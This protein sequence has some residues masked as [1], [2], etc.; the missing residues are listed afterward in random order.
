MKQAILVIALLVSSGPIFGDDNST[1][2]HHYS[3]AVVYIQQAAQIRRSDFTDPTFFDRFAMKFGSPLYES[4]LYLPLISG[5]GFFVGHDG[6][7]L[8]NWHVIDT[9]DR[10]RSL[11]WGP[12]HWIWYIEKNFSE[13]EMPAE[14]KYKFENE[15]ISALAKAAIKTLVL[16]ENREFVESTTVAFDVEKDVALLQTPF[17][18]TVMLN[19]DFTI[20]PEA[21][22]DVFS[23]GY[24]LGSDTVQNVKNLTVTFTKGSVSAIRDGTLA[25]EH[26]ATIN[27]GSSGGPLLDQSGH[28]LGINTAI[29]TSSN[30]IYYAVPLR[31]VDEFLKAN[32]LSLETK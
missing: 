23:F 9:Q 29:K 22:T 26:T 28:V 19:M 6:R 10:T 14:E 4:D 21:G 7:V 31:F 1:F 20:A 12:V 3:P 11:R 8:T 15:L 16:V 2:F 17:K 5:S 24:P 13:K 18:N 25:I 30:N 27:P 32:N